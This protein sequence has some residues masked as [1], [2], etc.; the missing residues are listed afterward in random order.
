MSTALLY[1]MKKIQIGGHHKDSEIRGYALV[2][3]ENFEWLNQWK[4]SHLK[5]YD[6]TGY[7]VK[8]KNGFIL[9]HRLI[10]DT[11]KGME[12]DHINGNSLDNR[13]ENLR[14]CTHQQNQCNQ[15]KRNI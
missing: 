10:M 14:N 9:M 2:D 13:K 15:R 6:Y 5:S 8:R 1:L 7:V 3:D 4:W 12:V 11:P